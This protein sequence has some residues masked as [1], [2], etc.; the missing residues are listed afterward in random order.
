MLHELLLP[1]VPG[2]STTKHRCRWQQSNWDCIRRS[3]LWF[4]QHFINQLNFSPILCFWLVLPPSAASAF[5][6]IAI[7]QN[8]NKFTMTHA[9]TILLNWWYNI[10]QSSFDR[11]ETCKEE[12]T[13][14]LKC[15]PMFATEN[16][17]IMHLQVFDM[18][19]FQNCCHR[20]HR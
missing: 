7:L 18:K 4:E 17:K 20:V 10:E 9:N 8:K 19:E 5:K 14:S 12:I 2:P 11:P 16:L 1:H 13:C 3:W 6:L 15:S